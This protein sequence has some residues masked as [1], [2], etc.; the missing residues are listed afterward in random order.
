MHRTTLTASALAVLLFAPAA[1]L[2]AADPPKGDKDLDGEWEVVSAIQGGKEQPPPERKQLVSIM[3]EKIVFK[4]GD[5]THTGTLKLDPA[6][7]PRTFD[8]TPDDGPEKGKTTKG[9]YEIKGDEMKVC[10]GDA[11]ADRPKEFASKE[12]SGLALVTLKRVKK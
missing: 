5:E 6:K 11:G 3:G 10:H 9:I 7:T 12:G 1:W 8:L 4:D 2:Y